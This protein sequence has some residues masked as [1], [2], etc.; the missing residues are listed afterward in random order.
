M[1]AELETIPASR[2][3]AGGDPTRSARGRP[4]R[5]WCFSPTTTARSPS[6]T[7]T[8]PSRGRRAKTQRAALH[9]LANRPD[10]S[11]GIVSGRRVADLRTRT[12]LPS[13]RLSRRV[14]TAWRSKS[15]SRRWQHPDLGGRARTHPC[16]RRTSCAT[17]R[18]AGAGHLFSRT[19]HASVAVHVRGVAPRDRA[20]ADAL[21]EPT[22]AR[23]VG[24][25]RCSV[26]RLTGNLVLEFLPNVACHKGDA[27]R[28]I[29]RDVETPLRRSRRGS[30]SSATM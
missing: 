8:R 20:A 29:A 3:A 26:R 28:W 14:C 16:A 30:C 5:G 10:L 25:E 22:P 23:A 27:T 15:A 7:M 19:K 6:F 24:R 21:V 17:H 13:T 18:A 2:P 12:Q 9:A 1:T 11:L 4:I